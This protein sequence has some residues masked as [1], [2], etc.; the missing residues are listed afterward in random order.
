MGTSFTLLSISIWISRIT[1]EKDLDTGHRTGC[2]PPREGRAFPVSSTQV[3][4]VGNS[5]RERC[6]IGGG[7]EGRRQ[8]GTELWLAVILGVGK[9]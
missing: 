2:Q 7:S 5:P 9:T 1:S 4:L 8:V 6:E 3:A